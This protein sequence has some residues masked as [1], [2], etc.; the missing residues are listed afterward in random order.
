LGIFALTPEAC[1]QCE[2][3]SAKSWASREK[4]WDF[5]LRSLSSNDRD[6]SAASDPA[7]HPY[8]LQTIRKIHEISKEGGSEEL[9]ARAYPQINKL[10]QRCISAL[11]QSQTSHGVLLLTILQFFLDFGEV[12]LHD[13]DPS[14]KTFFCSCLILSFTSKADCVEWEEIGECI[15]DAFASN[16]VNWI[17]PSTF[18]YTYGFTNTSC[19]FGKKF[20]V[21][22]WQQHWFD[23]EEC[24]T[25]DATCSNG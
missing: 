19:G 22:G 5:H 18:P 24:S 13:A 20:W 7:T 3:G 25:L 6:S 17:V 12:V 16:D 8:I 23:P 1:D 15:Y 2:G 9:V 21:S 14:L 4:E 11:P 10:F